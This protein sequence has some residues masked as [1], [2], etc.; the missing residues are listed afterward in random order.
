MRIVLALLASSF[1]ATTLPALAKDTANAPEMV[2]PDAIKWDTA[3]PSL[4]KGAQI[5]VLH[6]DPGKPGAF[7]MRL[8]VPAG[9]K[10]AP[11]WHSQAENQ[12]VLSGA[13]YL[14]K[15]DKMDAKDAHALKS[16]GFH[17]LGA[18]EQHYAFT[19]SPTVVQINGEGPFDINYVNE[20]DDPQKTAKK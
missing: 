5:A 8:K 13:L 17:Y 6:G 20:A 4:P 18:K 16:G 10:I 1:L 2:N 19:K 9:Y 15:G 14:G 12:T 3:P 7:V 11:H